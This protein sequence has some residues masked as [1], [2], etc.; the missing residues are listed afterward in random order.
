MK[1]LIKL[2][3][4]AFLAMLCWNSASAQTFKFGHVNSQELIFLT[5]DYDS[6][7]V[8]FTAYQQN[9][10]EQFVEM[11][12]EFQNKY[13]AFEK[14]MNSWTASV[15]EAKQRELQEISQRTADFQQSAQQELQNMQAMLLNPVVEKVTET[16]NRIGKEQGF[17]YIFDLASRAIPYHNP[18]QSTDLMETLKRA[19][20]IPL[21][22]KLPIGQ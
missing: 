1:T 18:D 17:T 8:K 6:A 19:L 5:P 13:A 22:K 9:L 11:Q 14:N 15:L 4:L 16:I 12:T 3:A 20:N 7:M 2:F 21:D 10:E